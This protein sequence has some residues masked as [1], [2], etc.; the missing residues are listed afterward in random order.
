MALQISD[1]FITSDITPEFAQYLPAA[2]GGGH[3]HLSWLPELTLTRD[4]AMSGMVL[5]ETLS[6]LRLVDN[7]VAVDLAAFHAAEIGIDLDQAM[8]RLFMRSFD[9]T[10]R[11]EPPARP[12]PAFARAS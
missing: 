2:T 5:D 7:G 1:W 6:D 9:D 3:W 12:L 10:S 4:Q 11:A 8:F